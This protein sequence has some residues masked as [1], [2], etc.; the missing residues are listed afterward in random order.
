MRAAEK[1]CWTRSRSPRGEQA[2]ETET[3]LEGADR[4]AE[5][6]PNARG[7]FGLV[8]RT[9]D[10]RQRKRG[11]DEPLLR[12]GDSTEEPGDL[13]AV[14][15]GGVFRLGGYVVQDTDD[16]AI[17]RLGRRRLLLAQEPEGGGWRNGAAGEEQ[18]LACPARAAIWVPHPARGRAQAAGHGARPRRP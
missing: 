2:D 7:L 13:H 14:A 8:V 4:A 11:T 9:V 5:R 16:D 18:Q 17:G 15:G 6:Q 1:R 12:S 10:A 3:H